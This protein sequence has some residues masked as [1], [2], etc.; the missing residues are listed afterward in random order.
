MIERVGA[1]I[2]PPKNHQKAS[3]KVIKKRAA[4]HLGPSQR[5]G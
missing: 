3:P 1:R 5:D 4:A 2:H